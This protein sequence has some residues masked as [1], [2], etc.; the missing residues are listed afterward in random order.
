MEPKAIKRP[1]QLLVEGKDYC[2]FFAAFRDH[3]RISKK[4]MQIQNY[5]GVTGLHTF[6]PVLVKAPKF[7]TTVR[8]LGIVRDAESSAQSALQSVR[9]ALRKA[10]L[11]LPDGTGTGMPGNPMVSVL[12]LPDDGAGMLETVLARSFAGTR[13]DDCI[14][15]FLQCVTADGRTIRRPE[16]ARACAYLATTND[17]H[18][19]VGVAAKK[20]VWDFEHAAFSKVG[21]FLSRLGAP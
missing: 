7:D 5:G 21:E 17:P 18:V 13:E 10:N 20:G 6:L 2:N 11:A 19:S 15:R 14:E 8:R 4:S 3:L 16:K 1:I 12:V 9:S